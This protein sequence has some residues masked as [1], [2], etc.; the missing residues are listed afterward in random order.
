[1]I[2]FRQGDM[3]QAKAEALVNTVNCVG[4]MGRGVALQFRNAFPDNYA[5]YVVACKRHEVEP[6]RMFITETGQFENPRYII[7]F[8]TKRHWKGKSRIED[9]QLGLV[10]L[11]AD[12]KRLD[13]RSVAIPP[14][15][16]GLG[17]LDWAQV[18]PL[19]VEAFAALPQVQVL[20][21]EPLEAPSILSMARQRAVP[22][23]TPG[24][25]AL[26]S[27]LHR[28]LGGLMDPFVTLL[29]AHKLMYFMQ[30]AGQ[31]L[32][33]QYVKG[34]YGPF[35]ENLSHVLKAVEGHMLTGYADGG[36]QPDK[37]LELVPGVIKDAETLLASDT[38]SLS[39]FERV[40]D[41]VGGFETPY[42]LELLSTVHFVA[43]RQ[44]AA[45]PTEAL[46][47]VHSWNSRKRQFT[48]EQ[49]HLAWEI[50]EGKGWLAGTTVKPST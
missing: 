28:Y 13:I 44:G 30:E 19:I 50:L 37:Q 16:A 49:V 45:T 34:P 5:K 31:P 18:R 4:V 47:Q 26:V 14:L 35:A 32:R 20:I 36:D 10:D 46:E 24:R 29:E 8:P 25:A 2:E 43:I 40:A 39:R 17:G 7:N 33:L 11:V 9:I 41:L 3:L 42:G 23:M 27:L 21:Y 6:G 38:E 22:S 12:V 15:G 48:S 1:M